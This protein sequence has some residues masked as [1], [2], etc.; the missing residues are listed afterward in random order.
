M[1]FTPS[2]LD[3]KRW[4]DR[5]FP[6]TLQIA[7]WL[8]YLNGFFALLAWFDNR[9]EIGVLREYSTLGGIFGLVTIIAYAA[10]GFL[11][12]NGLRLGYRIAIFA[13]VSPFIVNVWCYR[14]IDKFPGTDY[15]ISD[16][17]F[18]QSLFSFIFNVA[19][20]ALLLHRHSTNHAKIWLK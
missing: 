10:G 8:L 19:L 5:M 14:T 7:T 1:A 16:Y 18:G 13:A 3:P 20:I 2:Q 4:F 12:A 9:D 11:M 15:G 17:I 6:Q